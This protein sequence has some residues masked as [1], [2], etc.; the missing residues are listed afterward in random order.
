M[1]AFAYVCVR[2]LCVFKTTLWPTWVF[3]EY[4]VFLD[5]AATRAAPTRKTADDHGANGTRANTSGDSGIRT[6][7]VCR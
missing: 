1:C 2:P 5:R 6:G 4:G 7:L 3:M